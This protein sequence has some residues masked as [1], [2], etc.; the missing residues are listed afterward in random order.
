MNRRIYKLMNPTP[1][2]DEANFY[3]V[4]YMKDPS[5][6]SKLSVRSELTEDKNTQ[7]TR[8]I[9]NFSPFNFR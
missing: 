3:L 1:T 9:P 2:I 6:S 7:E 4:H 8:S 5:Q